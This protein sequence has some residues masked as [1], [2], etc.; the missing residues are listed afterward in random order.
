M[1]PLQRFNFFYF[2]KKNHKTNRLLFQLLQYFTQPI[3]SFVLICT[4][5][6]SKELFKFVASPIRFL[7]S[8]CIYTRFWALC[9]ST[10][11]PRRTYP[12]SSAPGSQATSGPVSTWMGDRL[13]IRDAVGVHFFFFLNEE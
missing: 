1:F 8:S 4:T 6:S 7:H 5:P 2:K 10:A 11:I 3:I 9:M 13:G 12:V